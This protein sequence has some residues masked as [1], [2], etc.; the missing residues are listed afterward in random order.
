MI[1]AFF[2]SIVVVIAICVIWPP[3][4]VILGIFIG[5][6]CWPA[7]TCCCRYDWRDYPPF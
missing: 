7:H 4:A 3:F 2:L 1:I 5:L 6:F